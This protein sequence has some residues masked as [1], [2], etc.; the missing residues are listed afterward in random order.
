MGAELGQNWGR[1]GVDLGLIWGRFGADL[2]QILGS[3]LGLNPGE[4]EAIRGKFGVRLWGLRVPFGTGFGVG[5]WDSGTFGV[6]FRIQLR[7][8]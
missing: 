6:R 1:F 8:D 7:S 4:S 2:G 3:G 5:F